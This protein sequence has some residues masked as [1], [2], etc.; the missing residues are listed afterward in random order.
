M[1]K[2]I[3][4][5]N[6]V[7]QG[8]PRATIIRGRVHVYDPETSRDYKT[9]VRLSARQYAP[10]NPLESPLDVRLD[11]YRQIPKSFSKKRKNECELGE[12]RPTTRPDVDNY[13]K[14]ILD[15]LN[16][17]IFKDDSQIVD[18]TVSKYYSK[19]PRVEVQIKEIA[20]ENKRTR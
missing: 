4:D 17:L 15:G 8:R 1:I 7:A 13:I 12:V 2:F 19:S 6:P 3:I 18:L 9:Y 10:D 20:N 16:G 11:I 14:S 5:G